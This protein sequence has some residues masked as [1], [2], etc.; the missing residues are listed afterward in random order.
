MFDQKLFPVRAEK[1]PN[2]P[3][4][5]YLYGFEETNRDEI[6]PGTIYKQI[7][8]DERRHYLKKVKINLSANLFCYEEINHD[9]QYVPYNQFCATTPSDTTEEVTN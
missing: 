9:L 6:Q 7:R 4:Q 5:T 8:T 2:V 1:L 3:T